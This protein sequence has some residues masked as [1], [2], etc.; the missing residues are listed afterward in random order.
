MVIFTMDRFGNVG[1]PTKRFNQIRKLIKRG[2]VRMKG[3]GASGKPVVAMFLKKVFNTGRTVN[4]KFAIAIHPGYKT[5]GFAVVEAKDNHLDVLYRGECETGIDKIR[6]K[7][8]D[9]RTYRRR[10]RYLARFRKRRMAEKHGRPLAKFKKPRNVRSPNKTNATLQ[11]GVKVH[12]NLYDKLLKL[13]PLP[14]EQTTKI[15]E[16]NTFNRSEEHT[17]ELQSH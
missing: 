3:G 1:H 17:S 14:A 12:L 11:Y 6:G 9:R 13:C 10:K 4:R 15:M 5:I 16:S 7:M 8:D 2:E